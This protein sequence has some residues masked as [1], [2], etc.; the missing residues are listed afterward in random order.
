M[1]GSRFYFPL[2]PRYTAVEFE[3]L[4]AIGDALKHRAINFATASKLRDDMKAGKVDMV[5]KTLE[6]RTGKPLKLAGPIAVKRDRKPT[7]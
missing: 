3:V 2:E 7:S 6:K 4:E 5:L 1:A